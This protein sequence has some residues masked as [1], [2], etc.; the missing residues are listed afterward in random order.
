MIHSGY[1]KTKGENKMEYLDWEKDMALE[2]DFGALLRVLYGVEGEVTQATKDAAKE[3]LFTLFEDGVSGEMQAVY[4][5][6]RYMLGRSDE[7]IFQRFGA[8]WFDSMKNSAL[9][10]MRRPVYAKDILK[11]D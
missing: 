2:A 9:R 7:E 3:A 8:Y 1:K 11:A 6:Q 4:L 10:V 5:W